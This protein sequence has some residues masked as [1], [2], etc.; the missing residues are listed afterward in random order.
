[1]EKVKKKKY[2]KKKIIEEKEISEKKKLHINEQMKK[3]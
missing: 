1:V 3:Y 2:I